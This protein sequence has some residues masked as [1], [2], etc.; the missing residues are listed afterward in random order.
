MGRKRL[1]ETDIRGGIEGLEGWRL[2][3][4]AISATYRFDRYDAA[5]AFAV[6]IAL[7]AQRIDHHPDLLIKWGAV[8]VTWTTHDAGGV[9][10]N[11]LDAA[12]EV[13]GFYRSPG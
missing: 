3:G 6:R 12:A 4:D 10:R 8:T 7:Y 1:D 2:E 11:D 5:V 9:T 13:A